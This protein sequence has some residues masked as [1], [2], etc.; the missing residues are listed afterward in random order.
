MGKMAHHN[1]YFVPPQSPDRLL[2]RY[3]L[4]VDSL[5]STSTQFSDA[6]LRDVEALAHACETPL[7]SIRSVSDRD[8]SY[9]VVRALHSGIN[10]DQP[11]SLDAFLYSIHFRGIE[12]YSPPSRNL[13]YVIGHLRPFQC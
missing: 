13:A 6:Y 9:P 10:E 11:P 8:R 1:I 2:S 5:V 7:E 3:S 4:Q 12:M